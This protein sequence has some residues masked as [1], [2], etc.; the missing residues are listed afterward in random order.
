[1]DSARLGP[2]VVA[3]IGI[4]E[5]AAWERLYAMYNLAIAI[6]LLYLSD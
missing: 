3:I 6:E 5:D 1:M 2:L 4:L